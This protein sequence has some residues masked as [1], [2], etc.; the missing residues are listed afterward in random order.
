MPDELRKAGATKQEMNKAF[1]GAGGLTFVVPAYRESPHLDACLWSLRQQTV[2]CRILITTSTPCDFID[3][4][5][6]KHGVPVLVNGKGGSIAADWNFALEQAG[7]GLVTLAHQDDLYNERYAESCLSALRRN[8][9]LLMVF[10]D[11]AE[12]VEDGGVV[13]SNTAM[14]RIKRMLLF[15][16]LFRRSIRSRFVKKAVLRLGS[17]ICCP[18][19]CLNRAVIPDF[20]FLDDYSVNMD[21]DAWLRLADR[22]GPMVHVRERYCLHRIHEG[23]ETSSGIRENRRAEEDL[24]IFRRLWPAPVARL[25]AKAYSLSYKSNAVPR[26]APVD[27]TSGKT[28]TDED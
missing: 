13:R 14:L 8:T 1:P 5:A 22:R 15:P 23:S 26:N 4:L 2:P 27:P 12:V 3:R 21:W 10:T 25:L 6:K 20:R 24:R 7:E 18:S 11:Y 16:Y 28:L 17:P 9:D 19:V